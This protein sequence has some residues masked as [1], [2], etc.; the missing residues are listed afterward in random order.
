MKARRFIGG[1]LPRLRTIRKPDARVWSA[2]AALS[3]LACGCGGAPMPRAESQFPLAVEGQP[4]I[5]VRVALS[6]ERERQRQRWVEGARLA[7]RHHIAMLGWTPA[8]TLTV[9]DRAGSAAPPPG[10][11]EREGFSRAARDVISVVAPLISSQRGLTV[12]A[13]VTRETARTFWRAAVPCDHDGGSFI[14]GLAGYT[15]LASLALQFDGARVPPVVGALEQ[16]YFGGLV[17]WVLRVEVPAWTPPPR[18][19]ADRERLAAR[20]TAAMQTLA[21]W[22]GPPAAD[23]T[24]RS[25]VAAAQGQCRS[26]RELQQA[27][28]D[29]TG[30][31]LSWFFDQAFGANRVFDYGIEQLTSGRLQDSGRYRT[32]VLVRRYG[33][34]MFTGTSRPPIEPFDSGRGVEIAVRFAD[35]VERLDEWDGRAPQRL[36]E[37]ES[38]GAAESAAVDPRRVIVLDVNRMNNTA[39]LAPKSARAAVKWSALWTLWLEHLLLTFGSLV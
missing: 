34:G 25:F 39:T 16:R 36:F 22:I 26:W 21:N 7:I 4:T 18:L 8:T 24:L 30:L 5:Q 10:F 27:A 13:A 23:A 37:Y 35:G 33:D 32:R 38:A 3:L 20:T 9:V 6:P 1:H 29:V 17:P 28:A 14:D 11:M 15:A 2:L 31:D 12:E 19:A